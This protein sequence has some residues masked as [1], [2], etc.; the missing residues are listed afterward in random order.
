M[1]LPNPSKHL[2]Q[3]LVEEGVT[4]TEREREAYALGKLAILLELETRVRILEEVSAAV[5]DERVNSHV[6]GALH[7]LQSSLQVS[8]STTINDDVNAWYDA[9]LARASSAGVGPGSR[10]PRHGS[11]VEGHRVDTSSPLEGLDDSPS[12]PTEQRL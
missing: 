7:D 10:V 1:I 12:Q 3:A 2:C 5:L 4:F 6:L 9:L 8:D 11:T